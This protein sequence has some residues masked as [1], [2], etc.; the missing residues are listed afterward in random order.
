MA[1]SSNTNVTFCAPSSIAVTGRKTRFKVE[2]NQ[3]EDLIRMRNRLPTEYA[4]EFRRKYGNILDLLDIPIAKEGIAA[5]AQYWDN[6]MRC[7]VFPQ[8]HLSLVV[9]EYA[10]FLG[11][12]VHVDSAVYTYP[13]SLPSRKAV[14]QLLGRTVEGIPFKQQGQMQTISLVFLVGYM[15]ALAKKGEWKLFERVLALTVYGVVLFPFAHNAV[16]FAAISVFQAVEHHRIN[17]ITA[18]L[19]DTYL[20]LTYC[21]EKGGGKLKCCLQLLTVWMANHFFGK[22]WSS[23]MRMDTIHHPLKDFS[24]REGLV[25]D[26]PRGQEGLI[27]TEY[28]SWVQFFNRVSKEAI[29]WKLVWWIEPE[30]LYGCGDFPNVPLV[31]PRGG[32]NYNPSLAH[33]QL[34]YPQDVPAH[35]MI[36]PLLYLHETSTAELN[37]RIT[38][39][40]KKMHFKGKHEL[41]TRTLVMTREY[42]EWVETRF[43]TRA[44]PEFAPQDPLLSN[45]FTQVERG[46]R[47]KIEEYKTEL[48]NLGEERKRRR[49]DMQKSQEEYVALQGDLFN[50]RGR[51]KPT[52]TEETIELREEVQ[53]LKA[54]IKE[55]HQARRVR[56]SELHKETEVYKHKCVEL[57]AAYQAIIE[58]NQ[59]LENH[60]EDA[61]RLESELME[62]RQRIDTLEMK[63]EAYAQRLESFELEH[64]VLARRI[65][66]LK[67]ERNRWEA[68]AEALR[69]KHEQIAGFINTA[70]PTFVDTFNNAEK[71]I[72]PFTVSEELEDLLEL[73]HD[74]VAKWNI[75][76]NQRM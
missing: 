27:S 68:T 47:Q 24:K 44:T 20:S 28:P 1:S 2:A 33:L 67:G 3:I 36:Q 4:Q 12:P 45:D 6:E 38:L 73:G 41:G 18:I 43:I 58:K 16:D 8:F 55:L 14:A 46:L 64:N 69:K 25:L 19:A 59:E 9:E 13:N 50:L 54:E 32:I 30:V 65:D 51:A 53:R 61:C 39:A 26:N 66:E 22:R 15:E 72:I 42:K 23:G 11:Q 17:P 37:G 29:R 10:S 60:F 31:G 71:T 49:K 76:C 7:F 34:A 21:M 56:D 35:D 74:L 40:W 48:D 57:Q 75:L 62:E 63:N 70:I 5:L 52:E